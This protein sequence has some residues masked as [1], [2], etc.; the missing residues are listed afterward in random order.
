MR[1]ILTLQAPTFFA[2][3]SL[4]S[5]LPSK[6]FYINPG[7]PSF[8]LLFPHFFAPFLHPSTWMHP[9]SL[10][11]TASLSV[12]Q[13][14]FSPSPLTTPEL[15]PSATEHERSSTET[16]SS[17]S[18]RCT[19]KGRAAGPS[20]PRP[21]IAKALSP[22]STSRDEALHTGQQAHLG[23]QWLFRIHL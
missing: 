4:P 2:F 16:P 22:R 19:E 15:T 17:Q 6:T 3:H 14:G 10:P 7:Y 13:S 21:S 9:H 23:R 12:H 5:S 11:N 20:L 18:T 1:S 8:L